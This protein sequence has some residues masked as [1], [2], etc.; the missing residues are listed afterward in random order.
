MT[1]SGIF[2]LRSICGVL[3]RDGL[4]TRERKSFSHSDKG[5]LEFVAAELVGAATSSGFRRGR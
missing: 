1:R 2:K 5:L 4:K 3:A